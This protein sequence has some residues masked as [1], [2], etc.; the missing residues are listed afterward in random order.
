[1]YVVQLTLNAD[2]K[3]LTKKSK[4]TWCIVNDD[5]TILRTPVFLALSESCGMILL[6]GHIGLL[7]TC[8]FKVDLTV[9]VCLAS[10]P[11]LHLVALCNLPS[12]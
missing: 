8:N 3:V 2:E 10:L 5:P 9:D 12:G 11:Y 4:G 1:M 6:K 7:S